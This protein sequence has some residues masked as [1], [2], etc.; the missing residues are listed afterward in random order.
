M[1]GIS[2]LPET[3]LL[4]FNKRVPMDRS[5]EIL[6]LCPSATRESTEGGS[7]DDGSTEVGGDAPRGPRADSVLTFL[8]FSRGVAGDGAETSW[9]KMSFGETSSP[10]LESESVESEVELEL[11]ESEESDESESLLVPGSTSPDVAVDTAGATLTPPGNGARPRSVA[12]VR[13]RALRESV[14]RRRRLR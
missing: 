11:D 8:G 2:L 14:R 12:D 7:G 10:E 4:N 13:A 5:T 6:A 3:L 9:P 1:P